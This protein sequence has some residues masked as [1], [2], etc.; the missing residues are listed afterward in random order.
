LSLVGSI[1]SN[2]YNFLSIFILSINSSSC[3]LVF[4]FLFF[5]LGLLSI[6]SSD[7]FIS[8]F[9]ICFSLFLSIKHVVLGFFQS[10]LFFTI[11]FIL[12]LTFLFSSSFFI[13]L[14]GFSFFFSLLIRTFGIIIININFNSNINWVFIQLNQ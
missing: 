8:S 10:S 1:H 12:D 5:V 11:S 2:S 6:M 14:L 9:L 13:S 7:F 4:S 3:C